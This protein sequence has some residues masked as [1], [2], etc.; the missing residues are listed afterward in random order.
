[1]ACASVKGMAGQTKEPDTGLHRSGN[2]DRART[3]TKKPTRAWRNGACA[4]ATVDEGADGE[5]QTKSTSVSLGL[6]A[7]ARRVLRP[8]ELS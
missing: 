3:L 5:P 8:N 2:C 4:H 7:T 6:A 1:M